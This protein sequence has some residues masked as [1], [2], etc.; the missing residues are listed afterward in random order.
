MTEFR[1]R[2]LRRGVTL[3]AVL[4]EQSAMRVFV[5]VARDAIQNGLLR[6]QAGVPLDRFYFAVLLI[7]PTQKMGGGQ[8]VF[9]LR[10]RIVFEL[11]ESDA[12]QRRMIHHGQPFLNTTMFTVALAATAHIGVEGR[13]LALQE[14][15]VVRMAENATGSLNSL[16]GR[17]AGG[18][19]V[20]QKSVALGES[21]GTGHSLPSRFVPDPGTHVAGMISK[22]V[23]PKKQCN[24]EY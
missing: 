11:S 18:A 13:R 1:E 10:I 2:P 24:K 5:F 7:D 20:F 19:I 3:S 8:T 4:A 14:C 16:A 23:K 22:K 21:T 12:R 9:R 17:V 6:W 15:C